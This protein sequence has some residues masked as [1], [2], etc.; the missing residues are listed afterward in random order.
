[1]YL[2]KKLIMIKM[3][4]IKEKKLDSF[5]TF[6]FYQIRLKTTVD[7]QKNKKHRNPT[8]GRV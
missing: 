3:Y 8:K 6:C 5:L 2:K 7:K 4:S 1:M